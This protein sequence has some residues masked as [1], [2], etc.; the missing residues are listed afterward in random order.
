MEPLWIVMAFLVGL[1]V[2]QVGLPPL[3]GFLG[4]GFVLSMMGVEGSATLDQIADLGIY[5]LLFSIGLK[6]DLRSLARP[7]VWGVA[8]VHMLITTAAIGAGV[9]ALAWVGLGMFADLG[10]WTALLVAFALSFSSTVFAV[11]VLE[12]KSEMASRHGSEAIGVLIMQDLFAIVFLTASTGKM[13]SPWALLLLALPLARYPLRLI[14]DRTGHGE[15]VLL[16]GL[17]LVVGSTQLFELVNMKPDLGALIAGLLLGSHA[18]A[19]EL[20]KSLMSLKDLFLVAF[21]LTIGLE[22][23]PNLEQLGI[24]ALLVLL[25]PMKVILFF[26]LMTRFRLR[27]RTASLSTLPLTNFSEFGLIVGA[28][29]VQAGWI[30]GQWLVVIALALALSFVLAAPFNSRAHA[31]FARWA[32]RLQRF[33]SGKRL[34][35]DQHIHFDKPVHAVVIAMGRVGTAAYDTL[36]QRYGEGVIGLDADPVLATK[37]QEQG[38]QVICGD[39]TDPDFYARFDMAHTCEL[40]V[41]ALQDTTEV[42]AIAR[43]LRETGYDRHIVAMARYADEVEQ[44]REA[45]VDSAHYLHEEMGIGLAR[46]ALEEAAADRDADADPD[47]SPDQQAD[48]SPK[49]V[50]A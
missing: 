50:L 4:A 31:L 44:L 47:P 30:T 3:I 25:L 33:E 39:A 43:L 38:R 40:V 9:F 29:G 27:A 15:L 12:E 24:A 7:Q 36:R 35:D 23:V 42:I 37:R 46:S 26:W 34:P 49:P 16:M 41:I 18:K 22:G 48:P 10:P 2:K 20:A 19:N 28:V 32:D 6:L 45:G 14:L 13:P 17:L 8:S 5:L 21:F 11:K 1:L